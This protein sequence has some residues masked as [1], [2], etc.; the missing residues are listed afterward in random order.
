MTKPEMPGQTP[1]SPPPQRPRPRVTP[2]APPAPA[3]PRPTPPPP[4]APDAAAQTTT[5]KAADEVL[6]Y[7][8]T[9]AEWECL[10]PKSEEDEEKKRAKDAKK[11]LNDYLLASLSMQHVVVLAGSGTSLGKVGGP[12]MWDL[13]DHCVNTNP[14]SG[15][16]KRTRSP[17]AQEAIKIVAYEN[18]VANEKN[19]ENIETLLSQ[20]E[21]FLQLNPND[22]N[23]KT[24]VEN[25]NQT[26]LNQCTSFLDESKEGQL[27]AH[28]T[29]L[30][31]LSRRRARD[32]RL[33]V[34]TTNYDLCFESASAGQGL[35]QID[36]FSFGQPR[37]FDPRFFLYDIVKRPMSGN[38]LGTPLGGVFQMY[39]LH[40]SVNWS[41]RDDGVI[42]ERKDPPPDSA[43]LIYPAKGKYQQSYVQPHLEIISQFFAS[44]REPNTCLLVVGFG[45]N[46]DHLA[47]PIL[48]AIKTNPHL[49]VIVVGPSID[50][51]V[52]GEGENR[53]WASL[54]SDLKRGSDVGMIKGTFGDFAELIPDLKSN[55]PAEQLVRNMRAI[56]DKH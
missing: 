43:C 46:D 44:L 9:A 22:T 47:E 32:S 53:Y 27:D 24:F 28:R 51:H 33:K 15:D 3:G 36:G 23:V 12:S 48:T 18:A 55:T 38:D 30:H 17:E 6:V 31:R 29:F 40:G 45:F 20:C 10:T 11:R 2:P 7:N 21:A 16:D 4:Q 14:G 5:N 26:I 13:W 35:V 41:R 56:T 19:K 8:Q 25:S 54:F 52:E 49:R 37:T 39:K 34:F 42:E 50:K 1:P